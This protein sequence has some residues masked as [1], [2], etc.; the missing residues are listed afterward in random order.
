M[1]RLRELWLWLRAVPTMSRMMK[2]GGAANNACLATN[3]YPHERA[4]AFMRRLEARGW[5]QQSSWAA[6]LPDQFKDDDHW[7]LTWEAR[8]R[9]E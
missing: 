7:E 3:R 2:K 4:V 6:N 9:F 8:Q 5:V 1:A